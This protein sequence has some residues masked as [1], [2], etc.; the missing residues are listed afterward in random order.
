[1]HIVNTDKNTTVCGGNEVTQNALRQS[2]FDIVIRYLSVHLQR[3]MYGQE[4]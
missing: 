2:A 1:M 4:V 3:I